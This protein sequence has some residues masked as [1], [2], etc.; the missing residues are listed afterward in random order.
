LVSVSAAA[1]ESSPL[2]E[3]DIAGLRLTPILPRLLLPIHQTFKRIQRQDVHDNNNVITLDNR[4][5][6]R[7]NEHSKDAMIA[8]RKQSQRQ[9]NFW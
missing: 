7:H 2:D 8:H 1:D 6:T 5:L 4:H 9:A 3:Q